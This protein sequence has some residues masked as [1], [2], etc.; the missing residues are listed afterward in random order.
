MRVFENTFRRGLAMVVV[1]LVLACGP[2][3]PVQ[4][5]VTVT[6][7]VVTTPDTNPPPCE[8]EDCGNC[9]SDADCTLQKLSLIHI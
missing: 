7:D 5:D 2:V 9:Q 6:P 3:D 1:G 8:G 4:P